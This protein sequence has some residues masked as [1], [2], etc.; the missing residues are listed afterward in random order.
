M[1]HGQMCVEHVLACVRHVTARVKTR[2]CAGWSGPRG[3]W[4]IMQKLQMVHCGPWFL[5][6]MMVRQQL[7]RSK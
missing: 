3:A 6:F 1:T 5:P 4:D 7:D 2:G